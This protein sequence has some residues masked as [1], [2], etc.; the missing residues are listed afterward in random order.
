MKYRDLTQNELLNVSRHFNLLQLLTGINTSNDNE[1]DIVKTWLALIAGSVTSIGI[2][3]Q[4]LADLGVINELTSQDVK[5]YIQDLTLIEEVTPIAPSTKTIPFQAGYPTF[6]LHTPLDKSTPAVF[7]GLKAGYQ[8]VNLGRAIHVKDAVKYKVNLVNLS[9]GLD[10][11][12][13]K[14]SV[15]AENVDFNIEY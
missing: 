11:D 4:T 2:D 12:Q 1:A 14:V 3:E 5:G 8:D 15:N 7:W 9:G 6:T 13:L 10:Y